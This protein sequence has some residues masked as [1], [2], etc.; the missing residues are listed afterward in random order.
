[1]LLR[2]GGRCAQDFAIVR[3]LHK[4]DH[5]II[6]FGMVHLDCHVFR[7]RFAFVHLAETSKPLYYCHVFQLPAA[8]LSS[9]YLR[10]RVIKGNRNED[11]GL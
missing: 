3:L 9:Q 4:R 10:L 11:V 6:L 2:V 5:P 1:M 8:V 7:K